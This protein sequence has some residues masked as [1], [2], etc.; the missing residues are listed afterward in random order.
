[1]LIFEHQAMTKFSQRRNYRNT[2]FY[3]C[4]YVYE[5]NWAFWLKHSN[6]RPVTLWDK[7]GYSSDINIFFHTQKVEMSTPLVLTSLQMSQPATNIIIITTPES[8]N[9]TTAHIT[10]GASFYER[11]VSEMFNYPLQGL[12]D[13]RNLL[14]DYCAD[15]A[16]LAKGVNVSGYQE[17]QYCKLSDTTSPVP[18]NFFSI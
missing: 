3:Y 9:H 8:I 15:T 13:S 18:A 4:P 17:L 5:A 12:K 7:I 16:P 10:P 6:L 1:M 14:L 2:A 11:E